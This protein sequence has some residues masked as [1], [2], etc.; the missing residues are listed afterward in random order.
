MSSFFRIAVPLVVVLSVGIF[1]PH[2]H[3]KDCATD[4]IG[5]LDPSFIPFIGHPLFYLVEC[6]CVL[7][8]NFVLRLSYV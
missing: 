8:S 3:R 4:H 5:C 7:I 2:F 6:T 1:S